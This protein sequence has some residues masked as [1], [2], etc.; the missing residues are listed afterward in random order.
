MSYTLR[1]YQVEALAAISTAWETRDRTM[2]VLATG[3]GKTTVFT[4]VLRRR[5]DQLGGRA[6]VL[7]HR[8]EL[9]DQAAARLGQAGLSAELE[10]GGSRA[11]KHELLGGANVVVATM[12]TMRGK[13]LEEWRRDSFDTVIVDEAHH[14]VSAGYRAILDWFNKAKILG[15]TATPDR[16]DGIALGG[17]IDHLSYEYGLR[18]GIEEGY[19]APLRVMSVDMPFIDMS[20]VRTTKQEHGR[21]LSAE[22]LGNAMK[23][24]AELHKVAIPIARDAGDRKTLVFVPTVEIAH[25]LA[26]VL[27]AYVGASKVASL[28]GT[29]DKG[30]RAEVLKAYQRGDVQF[31]V[32]CA[33]FTEGF[34]APETSCVAIARPTKSRAL[35]TQMVGRGTRLAPGKTDCL[36][37]DLAPENAR[38]SLVS[39]VD[40]LD[41]DPLPDDLAAAAKKAAMAG[42]DLLKLLAGAEEVAKKREAARKLDRERAHVVAEA[43]YR[44]RFRDPFAELG[45]DGQVGEDRG[46]RATTSMLE[47]LEKCGIKLPV[48]PSRREASRMFEEIRRRRTSGLCTLKQSRLLQDKGLRGDLPFA[49]ARNAIDALASNGWKVSPAIAEAWGAQ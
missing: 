14:A 23:G 4:E 36:I 39:P 25:A 12:Q 17:V 33:L 41:G 49:E 7:A 3:L 21:D 40:L 44:K 24:K 22:D 2:L 15:V 32:N 30:D 20:K 46:P 13:R 43:A 1:P 16:G 18:R 6:L 26:E 31:L 48:V 9:L 47:A 45:I 19:L 28:D 5:R 34:D 29:S 27:S 8:L 38:H 37:L 35:Y 11:V 42:G 10:S